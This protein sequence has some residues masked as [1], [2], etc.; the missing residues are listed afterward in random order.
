M[1]CQL[2]MTPPYPSIILRDLGRQEN[3]DS[4]YLFFLYL[5]GILLY[6]Q[7]CYCYPTFPVSFFV[8]LLHTLAL[9]LVLRRNL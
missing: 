7:I 6:S 4:H 2:L 1:W 9:F 5:F 8:Y 3:C